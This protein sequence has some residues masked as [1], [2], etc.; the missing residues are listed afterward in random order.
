MHTCLVTSLV[1]RIVVGPSIFLTVVR[2]TRQVFLP[3]CTPMDMAL[4]YLVIRIHGN[5]QLNQKV[6]E[7]HY[8]VAITGPGHAVLVR[9]VSRPKRIR[10]KIESDIDLEHSK[11]PHEQSYRCDTKQTIRTCGRSTSTDITDIIKGT[12]KDPEGNVQIRVGK[13]INVGRRQRLARNVSHWWC[14]VNEQRCKRTTF[15][16]KCQ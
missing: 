11:P 13:D 15:Q 8:S 1:H 14:R 3:W 2:K 9:E 10:N 7:Y 4:D 5:V 16:Y 6:L 12:A